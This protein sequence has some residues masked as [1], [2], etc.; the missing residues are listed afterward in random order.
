MTTCIYI[1]KIIS[2]NVS[3]IGNSFE[4]G[5]SGGIKIICL[6]VSQ[7]IK[8]TWNQSVFDKHAHMHLY[9]G[10][11]GHTEMYIRVSKSMLT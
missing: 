1:Y 8:N 9:M 11:H 2:F 6:I 5:L 10:V 4:R 7:C 3:E